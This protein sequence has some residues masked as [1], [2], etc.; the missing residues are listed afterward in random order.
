MG[1]RCDVKINQILE[2]DLETRVRFTIFEG[3]HRDVLE[4]SR[5]GEPAVFVRRYVRE[6]QLLT[7]EIVLSPGM[8]EDGIRA[9]L[10][11]ELQEFTSGLR[12]LGVNKT[13][14]DEQTQGHLLQESAWAVAPRPRVKIVRPVSVEVVA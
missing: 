5:P 13:P 2:T 9:A 12:L 4:E 10:H 3:D 11:V 8:S 6:R 7:G 14:I 1:T